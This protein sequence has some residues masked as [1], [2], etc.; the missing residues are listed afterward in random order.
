[1]PTGL[2][3]LNQ[4]MTN[5]E[6]FDIFYNTL[7]QSIAKID[8]RFYKLKLAYFNQTMYRENVYCYELYYQL[9][10]M[11]GEDFP[12]IL[13]GEVDKASHPD[14]V[15]RCLEFKTS[16]LVHQPGIHSADSFLAIM[17]VLSVQTAFRY[18]ET[19]I[20]YINKMKCAIG[21]QGGYYSGI[22]L[23]YGDEHAE[24]DKGIFDIYK[25]YARD[26]YES[27][28]LLYHNSPGDKPVKINV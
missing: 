4:N 12:Y 10:T 17:Q 2:L 15:E 27:I 16:F 13:A 22:I 23:I 26:M 1:M 3:I 8:K 24:I 11:L 14:I 28:I 25:N 20:D 19:L 6:A 18:P 7:L 5:K 21:L 9:R